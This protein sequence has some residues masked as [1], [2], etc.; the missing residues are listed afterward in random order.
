MENYAVFGNPIDHSKSP[1]IHA[2]FAKQTGIA[3]RYGRVLAPR[4]TFEET[5]RAFFAGGGQGANITMPFKERAFS[6][7]DQ[8]TER[9]S[10]AG[11]VNTVKKQPDGAL[12]GDNTD[13]IGLLLDLQRIAF[14]RP[15]SRILLMGAGGAARGVILPLLSFGCAIT[16]TNRTFPRAQELASFYRHAGSISALPLDDLAEPE[17]DLIINATTSG[18]RGDVPGLAAGLIIPAVKCYDMYYRRG[19]TPFLQ[20]CAHLGAK[21]YTDGLGMLVGQAAYAFLLWH[22]V[23]PDI[24]PILHHLRASP[25]V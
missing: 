22:G 21:D 11:A 2:L 6:L 9:A 8:L 20:W 3:L 17:F 12:L 24:Q 14:I 13:G 16:L 5:L 7:C 18:V 10:Q 19:L 4:D 15:D 23:L 25:T 1:E